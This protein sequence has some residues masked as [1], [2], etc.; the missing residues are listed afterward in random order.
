MI[1]LRLVEW[2][3]EVSED[4]PNRIYNVEP[5]RVL[6]IQYKSLILQIWKLRSRF[7]DPLIAGEDHNSDLPEG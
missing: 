5:E 3:V 1:L 2:G 6:R 7:R 4:D